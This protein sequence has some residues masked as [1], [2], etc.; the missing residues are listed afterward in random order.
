MNDR[1]KMCV[2]AAQK[3]WGTG[4]ARLTPDMKEA[5][6]CS[7]LVYMLLAQADSCIE[8]NPHGVLTHIIEDVR[9]ALNAVNGEQQ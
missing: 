4:W 6:V 2:Q 1:A 5:Y 7:E 3:K 8:T 9:Q